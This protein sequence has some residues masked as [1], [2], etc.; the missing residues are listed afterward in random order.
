MRY[1]KTEAV[2]LK[3]TNW[4]ETDR[5]ITLFT[6]KYGKIHALAKGVRKIS[7]KYAA[8]LELFT[9]SLV[10][11]FKGKSLDIIT[12]AWTIKGFFNI[13]KKLPLAIAAFFLIEQIERLCAEREE[14]EQSFEL[15][16]DSLTKLDSFS[17]NKAQLE[18]IKE[19]FSLS[20]L[21]Q[22]GYLPK[23]EVLPGKKLNLFIEGILESRL[24]S[25]LLYP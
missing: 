16:L 22:L 6:R 15:L 3:R 25:R 1:Y 4:G 19:Q 8:H 12:E 18:R 24:K 13:R 9:H 11:L 17:S 2:I 5:I 7:S 21:M 14:L 23:G 10:Y 20:L